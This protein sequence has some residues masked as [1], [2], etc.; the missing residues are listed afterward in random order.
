MEPTNFDTPE[1]ERAHSPTLRDLMRVMF[2]HRQLVALSFLGVFGGA[3]LAAIL[4][5]GYEA[6][7]KILVKHERVDPVVTSEPNTVSQQIS[8]ELVTDEDLNSEVELIQSRDLLEKVVETCGLDAS[9]PSFWDFLNP[10]W[11]FLNPTTSAERTAKA[12]RRLD[13]RLKVELATKS[14]MIEVSY[15]S[16]DP[17]L[18]ARVLT[19]LG[20]AY[21]V[22]HLAVNRPPGAFNFFQ[23]QAEQ[24]QKELT[25]AEARLADFSRDQEHG[26]V[27]PQI[28]RDLVLQKA[29]EFEA[30][31]RQTQASIAQT[32]ERMRTL[33][34]LA[35]ATPSRL[36]TTDRK[37]DNP[38]LLQQLKSSLLTLE[39]QRIELL[40][41]F[42][43]SYRPV[44][45]IEAQIAQAQAAIAAE[46]K[47]PVREETTDRNPTYQWVDGE[48]A[49]ARADLASYRAQ[50]AATTQIVR[51]YRSSALLLDQKEIEH[52]DLIRTAKADEANYLLYLNKREEARISDALD[53]QRI[54]NVAIA[55]AATAPALPKY[56]RWLFVLLGILFAVLVSVGAAFAADYFDA[57][58]RTTDEVEAFLNTPVLAAMPNNAG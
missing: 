6:R 5:P 40:N 50:A 48:L 22:K 56:P 21:L 15:A 28:Q 26:A 34:E 46:D 20:D 29:N 24:Y 23:Q 38:Q 12:V 10:I 16:P 36:T 4:L 27:S 35:A 11:N 25:E 49:K 2:R 47:A 13:R 19:T 45:Q 1:D 55:E 43:P 18:S 41:K 44:Q 17:L 42:E 57:S 8:N 7:M 54:A 51:D 53:A 32:Q 30:A 31:L 39:L 58:F 14:N 3:I 33:D 52:Q 9:P 37:S